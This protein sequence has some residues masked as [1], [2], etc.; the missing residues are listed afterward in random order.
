MG[1]SEFAPGDRISITS[2]RGNRTHLVP[3]GR[4]TID[5]S[6]TLSSVDA[7]DLAWFSTSRRLSGPTAV[8]DTEHVQV[9][10][11]TG[12]FHLEKTLSDDGWL[13]L[14]FYVGGQGHGGIYFGEKGLEE[15]VLKKKAWSDFPPPQESGAALASSIP[16]GPKE[17]RPGN[18][19]NQAI[20][21]YLG[22]PVPPPPSLDPRYTR[23]SLIAAFK[24]LGAQLGLAI[25]R[26]DV[27]ESEFPF[28]LYGVSDGPCD[29][30]ALAK[31]F[32]QMEGY[33]YCGSVTRSLPGGRMSFAI[34]II[35]RDQIPTARAADCRRR[36]MIRLQML[37][38]SGDGEKEGQE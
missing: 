35:P 3:G 31:G 21:A 11:G 4:Y 18:R 15:T 27:D 12:S 2:L 20:L 19:A 5:G 16:A 38:V 24:S 13:H 10:R 36:L 34:D 23:P 33:D 37:A 1:A 25:D 29:Y 7:A 22:N 9:A 26:L 14:T 6:Y 28:I 32:R 17:T 30:H 8:R